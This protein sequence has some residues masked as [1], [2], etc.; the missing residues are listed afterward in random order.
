MKKARV[1][2]L[3][4]IVFCS[5]CAAPSLRYK[6][7]INNMTAQGQF[8]E[9]AD[10]IEAK[11]TKNYSRQDRALA[12]LD[13]AVLLH[14]AGESAKSDELFA[15]AQDRIEDLYTVSATKSTGRLLINDLTLPYSVAPFERALT[16]F[17]RAMNFL[18]QDNL[19]DAAVEARRAAAFLDNLRGSKRK[20]YND[21]PFVQ[22]FA[23]LIFESVGQ[24]D[25]ARICRVNAMDGYH[26][27]RSLLNIRPPDFPVP[28]NYNELA[29]VIIF[30]YNGVL[31]L[32]KSAT[33]QFAADKVRGMIFSSSESRRGGLDP[34]LSNALRAGSL[35]AVTIAY[36]VLEAQPFVITSSFVQTGDGERYKLQKMAD[37]AAAARADLEER[38]LGMW[39][40]AA[41]RAVVKQAAAAATRKAVNSATNDDNQIW[42]DLAGLFVNAVG[43]AVE[44]AD[45][46]QWFTLPAQIFMTRLFLPPGEQDIW[47][48]FS[49]GM[50]NIVAEHKF[51]K[52]QLEAGGR[53]F[54]H[55]RTAK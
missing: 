2:L 13:E 39:T 48:K 16:F 1:Y 44:K 22:Y 55:Y 28:A 21:D 27:M 30:H 5:A 37:L 51:A 46:R 47:L 31:P 54:L 12:Y 49:D 52:V 23:S 14:D 20:G 53:I 42:G 18:E 3:G 25:D 32:K 8:K 33:I 38:K 15:Q 6:T 45:T 17:Y 43:S 36:P 41:A 9:A 50:G 29:E 19:S 24:I 35:G 7:E 11:R 4:L 40:R 26:R 34:E 10:K